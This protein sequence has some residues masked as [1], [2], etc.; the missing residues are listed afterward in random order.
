MCQLLSASS[1]PWRTLPP[2]GLTG[3]LP[4]ECQVHFHSLRSVS[5][6]LRICDFHRFWTWVIHRTEERETW[7][8][9]WS[10]K[11]LVHST[12]N[13]GG[14]NSIWPTLANGR[15]E[16]VAQR[17]PSFLLLPWMISE[18]GFSLQPIWRSSARWVDASLSR[19]ASL[20]SMWRSRGAY[21]TVLPPILPPSLHFPS[22]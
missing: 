9:R 11:V 7:H 8:L 2:Q 19:C 4:W 5:Y 1:A 15:R 6:R 10:L 16:G 3:H 14:I 21:T 22:V 20:L 12:Q 18:H 17:S 13:P